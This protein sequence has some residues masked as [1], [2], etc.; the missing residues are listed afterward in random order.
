[1]AGTPVRLLFTCTANQIRSP[2]AAAVAQRCVATLGLP[3]EVWSA[4]QFPG[5][6]PADAR[7]IEVAA[8]H[9][10]DL[11][12]HCSVQVSADL[13]AATDLIVTMTGRHVVELA[14]QFPEAS[15]RTVTLREWAHATQQGQGVDTWTPSGVRAW[16]D[17]ASR[18]PLGALLSGRA[19]VADPVGRS[20]RI[21]RRTALQI[22]GL[23]R[24]CFGPDLEDAAG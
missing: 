13:V 2:F 9:D 3:V 21:H 16:A 6:E 18:R 19:V 15:R 7:M 22:E 8:R 12:A 10:I 14:E 11:S 24:T 5:G 23:V 17:G 1:M 20:R 4:G